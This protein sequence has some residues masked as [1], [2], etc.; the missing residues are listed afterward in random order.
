M[1]VIRPKFPEDQ[2]QIWWHD[3]GATSPRYQLRKY[4]KNISNAVD[5]GQDGID[6][7]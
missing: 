3:L 1:Q 6:F 2:H 7:M 4:N 5:A